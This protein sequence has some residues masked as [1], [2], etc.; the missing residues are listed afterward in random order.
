VHAA[1]GVHT[2]AGTSFSRPFADAVTNSLP[3]ATIQVLTAPPVAGAALLALDSIET[4]PPVGPGT[5]A[6]L[7]DGAL[8][9]RQA[10]LNSAARARAAG[11]V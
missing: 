11:T 2:R 4:L 5:V 3:H 9:A 8:A 1:R 7:L 6:M 10:T